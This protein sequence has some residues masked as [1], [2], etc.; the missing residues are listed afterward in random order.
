MIYL[1]VCK[2][3]SIIANHQNGG[4]NG[5]HAA[6]F[7][8]TS[9]KD[10]PP[11]SSCTETMV[12]LLSHVQKREFGSIL[13]SIN[14]HRW[15][16]TIWIIY[17]VVAGIF[18]SRSKIFICIWANQ[19][20][21]FLVWSS[22]DCSRMHR[23]KRLKR[24]KGGRGCCWHIGIWVKRIGKLCPVE[25]ALPPVYKT[26]VVMWPWEAQRTYCCTSCTYCKSVWTPMII[27]ASFLI[28][29]SGR[30][31]MDD[32]EWTNWSTCW[33]LH[34]EW[35]STW[36]QITFTTFLASSRYDSRNK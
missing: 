30:T 15:I 27:I 9:L 25:S 16:W 14:T 34:N 36:Q 6:R 18:W 32:K 2:G 10:W 24:I 20:I 22:A 26:D 5:C 29:L 17:S 23:Q 31:A 4:N 28:F 8:A 21:S 7:V 19:M 11:A 35:N 13:C 12:T 1:M 33:Q 3:K